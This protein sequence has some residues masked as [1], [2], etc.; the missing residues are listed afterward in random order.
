VKL[1]P[2]VRWPLFVAA[3]LALQVCS[4][5]VTIYLATANPS[6]AVEKDYY[7]KGLRWDEQ[8]QQDRRNTALGWKI[9]LDVTPASASGDRPTLRVTLLDGTGAPITDAAL[10]VE[11][12]HNARSNDILEASFRSS[13]GGSYSTTLPMRR[14]GLWDLRFT[15]TRG[16]D[17]FTHVMRRH[18]ELNPR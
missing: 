5:L 17:L 10:A 15:A 4:S 3:A 2:H 1:E 18:L 6:Y 13:E 8:R 9:A 16:E 7:Q 11:A 14:S 12:F